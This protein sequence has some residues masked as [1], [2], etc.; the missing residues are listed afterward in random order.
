MKKFQ[1]KLKLRAGLKKAKFVPSKETDKSPSV[2]TT[3][4]EMQK[5]PAS[6]A[7]QIAQ[8]QK[9]KEYSDAKEQ[10]WT[11][12]EIAELDLEDELEKEKKKK[13]REE[14]LSLMGE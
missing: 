5:S 7:S 8:L 6:V 14:Y 11:E 9:T 12:N 4:G 3:E 13:D 2:T 10:E 1:A